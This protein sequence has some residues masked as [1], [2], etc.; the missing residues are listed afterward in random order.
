MKRDEVTLHLCERVHINGNGDLGM[1][2]EL[3]PFIYNENRFM[4]ILKLTKGGM[5]YLEGDDGKYY[6]IPPKNIDLIKSTIK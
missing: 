4:L 2:S 3:K 6:S 1:C 5:V